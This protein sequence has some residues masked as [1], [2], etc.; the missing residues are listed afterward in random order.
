MPRSLEPLPPTDPC[1]LVAGVDEAG[2]GPLAGAVIAAAVIL[3]P[4]RP[5]AGLADSKTLSARRREVLAAAIRER[6]LAW[7]L[8]RAD[9]AEIDAI[10]ILWA[11]MRAMERAVAALALTPALVQVDGNRCPPGLGVACEAIVKGDAKVAAIAAASILAKVARDAELVELDRRWPAYGFARHKGYPTAE[12]LAA[13]ARLGPCPEHRRS[14][15]PVRDT[16]AG[17]D[18]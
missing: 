1:G 15:A 10:N 16:G 3:D 13:L 14:F 7:A 12:H 18:G 17:S 5:I 8:G 4:A 11:S 9:A 6:A 2:R